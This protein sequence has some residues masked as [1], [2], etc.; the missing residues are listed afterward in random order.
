MSVI[1]AASLTGISWLLA[2]LPVVWVVFLLLPPVLVFRHEEVV[3]MK[4]ILSVEAVA[5]EQQS[6]Y[7]EYCLFLI[8]NSEVTASSF[9]LR[10]RLPRELSP[11][12]HIIQPLG[13]TYVG[14]IGQNWVVE[15]IDRNVVLTFRSLRPGTT[16]I[17]IEPAQRTALCTM[18][19]ADGRVKTQPG[20]DFQISGGNAKTI[21]GTLVLRSPE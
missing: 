4:A 21:L 1:A 19:F 14:T 10:L 15:T 11:P 18:H 5:G 13:Q 2:L 16:G 3:A 12:G 7:T 8:N 9:N 6:G 17:Q 20:I